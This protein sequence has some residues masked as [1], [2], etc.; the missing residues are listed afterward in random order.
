MG[1]ENKKEFSPFKKLL[2]E[3]ADGSKKIAPLLEKDAE[4][5]E[6]YLRQNR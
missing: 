5:I 3:F 6:A 4:N 1:I 2:K